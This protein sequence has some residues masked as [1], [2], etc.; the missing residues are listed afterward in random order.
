MSLPEVAAKR[1]RSSTKISFSNE[2]LTWVHY[3]YNDALLV[4]LQIG[5][6][7]VKR[8]LINKGNSAEII[9]YGLFKTLGLSHEA[10]LNLE[11]PLYGFSL[12]SVF[13]LG[14][15]FLPVKAGETVHQIEFQVVNVPSPFNAIMGRTWLYQMEAVS[16]TFHQVLRFPEANTVRTIWGDQTM[17]K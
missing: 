2:D 4:T 14:R 10:L 1:V 7:D 6:F 8:I 15:I 5:K 12:S 11:S 13:L 9:Y 16:S 17:A 3:P